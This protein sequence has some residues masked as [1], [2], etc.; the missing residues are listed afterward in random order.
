[1]STILEQIIAW[2]K[3]EV[4]ARRQVLPIRDMERKIISGIP[5]H[6]L[7]KKLQES[8][9]P[10]IIAEFK[11]CSPS[12]GMIYPNAPAQEIVKAYSQAGASAISVLTDEKYFSGNL[13]D[14]KKART[15]TELPILRKDFIIDEYQL[16]EAW[17]AGADIVLLIAAA[18]DKRTSLQLARL[19]FDL[20][21]EVLLEIHQP[22]EID[23]LDLPISMVGVNNRNLQNFTVSVDTSLQLANLIPPSFVKISESGIAS[24]DTLRLL[25]DA[26]YNGFLIGGFFMQQADPGSACKQLIEQSR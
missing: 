12:K 25:R 1:M 26:G 7:K 19:A 8:S 21:M 10:G 5:R 4:A 24:P 17:S 23:Y 6:P 22:E 3:E 18:L 14:L 13:D 16:F 9:Y 11:R 15:I 20:E 2:K